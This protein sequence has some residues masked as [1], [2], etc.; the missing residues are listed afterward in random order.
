MLKNAIICALLPGP[1]EPKTFQ[2]NHYLCL[3]VDELLFLDNG[4]QIQ[5]R[6]HDTVTFKATLTMVACNLPAGRNVICMTPQAPSMH[7]FI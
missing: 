4:A 3:L 5:T 7:P 6:S 1:D 2:I